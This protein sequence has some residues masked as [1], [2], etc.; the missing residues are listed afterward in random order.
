MKHYSDDDLIDYLHGELTD[1]VDVRVH[2]HLL[3]CSDCRTRYD[4]EARLTELLQASPLAAERE[5]PA[6]IRAQVWA[7]IREA[8][9]TLLDRIRVFVRPVVAVPLAA[10]VALSLYVGIPGLH[11]DRAANAP[12][13]AAAYYFE[14]HAAEG[15]ENPLADHVN[16]SAPLAL[17]HNAAVGAAGVPLIAAADAATLDDV[18][19]TRE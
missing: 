2:A 19:A 13:V 8:E 16:T 1:A 15:Q 12:T 7:A 5:L 9:P 17:E 11:G 14:E 10:M 3:E 18:V 4:A 6:L